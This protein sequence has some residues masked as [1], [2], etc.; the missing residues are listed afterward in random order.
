MPARLQY[1]VIESRPM[2]CAASI[3]T[4]EPVWAGT[5]ISADEASSR[6]DWRYEAVDAC[7]QLTASEEAKRL[8]SEVCEHCGGCRKT[9][10]GWEFGRHD[11]DER[12]ESAVHHDGCCHRDPGPPE[13]NTDPLPAPRRRG[14]VQKE[15]QLAQDL[16]NEP[17][18]SRTS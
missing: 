5:H 8:G 18:T 17:N 15:R 9:C 16:W 13:P 4:V 11:L 10:T 2:N 1:V 6:F 3:Y 14:V 12:C 7:K